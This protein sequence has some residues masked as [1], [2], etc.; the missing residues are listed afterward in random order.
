MKSIEEEL[1]ADIYWRQGQLSIL[2]SIGKHNSLSVQQR[3]CLRTYIVPA[4]YSLWEGFIKQSFS[5]Y[6]RD[7]NKKQIKL[8]DLHLNYITHIVDNKQQ[9]NLQN[10]RTNVEDRRKCVNVLCEI[11]SHESVPVS[12]NI[13][14]ESNV[15]Y[16]VLNRILQTFNLNRIDVKWEKG[17]N[18][19][20]CFRNRIAHGENS[21]VVEDTDIEYFSQLLN[22]LMVVVCS[23]IVNGIKEER[24]LKNKT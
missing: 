8:M 7:I 14:T 19:L 10:A 5:I 20:L 1:E 9:T 18:K 23:L 17:L 12:E 4:I 11:F 24:Y 22:D 16:K 13:P 21:I 2:R 15:T 3:A 6:I